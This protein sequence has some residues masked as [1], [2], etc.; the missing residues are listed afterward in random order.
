MLRDEPREGPGS[1]HV[2][3]EPG[4][5]VQE[6]T[7]RTDETGAGE[8]FERRQHTAPISPDRP[9]G[10]DAHVAELA[11]SLGEPRTHLRNGGLRAQADGQDRQPLLVRW[12]DARVDR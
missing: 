12:A 4:I 5:N 7:G 3:A 2:R 6:I 8:A 10:A 11:M 1:D 9:E